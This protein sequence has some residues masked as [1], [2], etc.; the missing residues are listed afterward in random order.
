MVFYQFIFPNWV[1]DNIRD[2]LSDRC[3]VDSKFL[4]VV[5]LKFYKSD[6]LATDL[7][8]KNTDKLNLVQLYFV[9]FLIRF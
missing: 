6:R 2:E 5:D 9:L 1:L 7:K 3:W 4:S 8:R